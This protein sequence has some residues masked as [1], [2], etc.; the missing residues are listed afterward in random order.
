MEDDIK[1]KFK[2]LK[3]ALKKS[4]IEMGYIKSKNHYLKK[5]NDLTISV[6]LITSPFSSKFLFQFWFEFAVY[7]AQI[8]NLNNIT[9]DELLKTNTNI[10]RANTGFIINEERV[11]FTLND[12]DKTILVDDVMNH[13]RTFDAYF[14]KFET[15]FD[16]VD[17]LDEK[18]KLLGRNKY[19][20]MM[21]VTLGALGYKE[22]SK[23]FF[24]QSEGDVAAIKNWAKHVG[25]EL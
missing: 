13:L 4:F 15:L 9:D 5:I 2:E 25:I 12:I 20:F 10:L 17:F 23:K 21:A 3:I 7:A 16:F 1:E 8:K 19:S 11:V 14:K 18:N 22:K 6:K 24:L